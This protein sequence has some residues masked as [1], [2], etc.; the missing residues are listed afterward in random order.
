M[1]R[2]IDREGVRRL[3]DQGAQLVEI[4]PPNEYRE[5]HLPGAKNL[6]LRRLEKQAA[7]V[8]DR[9]RAVVVYCWDSA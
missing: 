8:L 4:L 9:H 1:P 2:E 7:E 5:E 6:P 3:V